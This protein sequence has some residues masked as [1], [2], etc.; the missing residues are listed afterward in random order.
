[1]RKLSTEKFIE[2]SK[3]V[4]GNKYDYNNIEKILNKKIL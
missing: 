1:M 2:K 3:N 4:H